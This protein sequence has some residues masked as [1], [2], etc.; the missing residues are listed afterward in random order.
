MTAV[1]KIVYDMSTRN[2]PY[3]NTRWRLFEQIAFLYNLK[4]NDFFRN[5]FNPVT[6]GPIIFI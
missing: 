3:F 4:Y 2:K 1:F 6:F 5:T